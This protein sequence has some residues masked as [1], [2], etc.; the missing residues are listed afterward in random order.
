MLAELRAL[1]APEGT[2]VANVN[3]GPICDCLAT[4]HSG[5]FASVKEFHKA[6]A[7][8]ADL[9]TDTQKLPD[10]M[11]ELIAFYKDAS[12]K[13][14]FTHG[15]MNSLNIILRGEEVVGIIDY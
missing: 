1:T 7:N 4:L 3:G 8:G 2:G 11:A 15:D 14:V 6:L 13:T 5:P 10:V 12:D 9:E